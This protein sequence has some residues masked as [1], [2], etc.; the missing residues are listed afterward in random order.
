MKYKIYKHKETDQFRPQDMDPSEYDMNTLSKYNFSFILSHENLYFEDKKTCDKIQTRIVDWIEQTYGVLMCDENVEL[1]YNQKKLKPS[2]TNKNIGVK[3]PILRYVRDNKFEYIFYVNNRLF[4]NDLNVLSDFINKFDPDDEVITSEIKYIYEIGSKGGMLKRSQV[5]KRKTFDKLHFDQKKKLLHWLKKFKSG[6]MYKEGVSLDNKLGIALYGPPGT[7]KS[8]TCTA[9]ANETNRHILLL[10]SLLTA[11]RDKILDIVEN[12]RKTHVIVLDEVDHILSRS[13]QK[14]K[15]YSD[16]LTNA[17]SIEE[18][19]KIK[20]TYLNENRCEMSDEEFLLKLLDSFGDDTD[21]IIVMN[22]NNP[23]K[24]NKN[25]LR[26][27][28]IDFIGYLG[29]CT[30]KMFRDITVVYFEDIDELLIKYK[31]KVSDALSMNITPVIL[32]NLLATTDKEY[33]EYEDEDEDEEYEKLDKFDILLNE[34][35]KEKK[36]TYTDKLSR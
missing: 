21:R 28:R 8:A 29:Y 12:C 7:A 30:L 14:K 9:I 24:I 23:D 26:P 5:N 22:T 11:P 10:N 34:L 15:T 35:L 27:G 20:D 32:I 13:E 4:S 2:N 1:I 17:T 31:D 25:Y 19:Q 36:Q 18:A 6:T 16:M 33:E 3:M